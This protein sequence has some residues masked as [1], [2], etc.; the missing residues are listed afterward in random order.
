MFPYE[1]G[2]DFVSDFQSSGGWTAVNKLYKDLPVNTEQI[3]NPARYEQREVPPPISVAE[4]TPTAAVPCARADAGTVGARDMATTLKEGAARKE[5][6][7]AADA[8]NGDAYRFDVCGS[9]KVFQLKIRGDDAAGTRDMLA[10]WEAYGKSWTEGK[11]RYAPKGDN[12]ALRGTAL[13]KAKDDYIA[14]V[15]SS[16]STLASTSMASL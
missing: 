3:M 9:E 15:L 2:M 10:A 1:Q 13:V 4:S 12:A 5:A 11:V 14:V 8:W 6:G 16:D 7:D